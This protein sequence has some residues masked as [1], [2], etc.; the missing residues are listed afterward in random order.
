[1]DSTFQTVRAEALFASSLQISQQPT[2]SEVRD[3]VDVVTLRSG[4]AEECAGVV[5]TEFG[6]HPDSAVRRMTWALATVR[7]AYAENSS[8]RELAFAG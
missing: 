2:A 7:S 5:A 3:A 1:M 6:E 8:D 4:G